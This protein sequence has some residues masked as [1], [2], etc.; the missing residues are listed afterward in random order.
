MT[1]EIGH[2]PNIERNNTSALL[3]WTIY[4]LAK[5]N[6]VQSQLQQEV[7]SVLGE[8]TIPTEQ[9][10]DDMPYLDK[11]LKE[12]LRLHPSV[13]IVERV[14]AK[15]GQLPDGNTIKAG[16]SVVSNIYCMQ[17]WPAYWG[18][19]AADFIPNRYEC[20]VTF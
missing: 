1:A 3:S 6:H 16:E 5:H 12:V 10:I 9:M 19:F 8:S 15:E 20:C 13:P 7:D 17:R 4:R 18:R 14:A 11:V 2:I